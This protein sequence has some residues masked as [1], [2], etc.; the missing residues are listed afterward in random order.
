MGHLAGGLG[1]KHVL[2]ILRWV[3]F[4]DSFNEEL[5]WGDDEHPCKMEVLKQ[6]RKVDS[7]RGQVLV[8]KTTSQAIENPASS[9]LQKSWE[10][11]KD[12]VV[13]TT[14]LGASSLM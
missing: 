10:A 8:V 4:T 1:C 3:D 9:S 2:T 14:L 6:P 12:T 7:E 11:R 13:F 5:V